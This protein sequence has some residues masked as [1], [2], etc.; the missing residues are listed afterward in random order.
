MGGSLGDCAIHRYM[1]PDFYTADTTTKMVEEY[2]ALTLQLHR[3]HQGSGKTFI[4]AN[5]E[6]DNALY[7]GSAYYIANADFTNSMRQRVPKHLRRQPQFFGLHRSDDPLD[8]S[9]IR[10]L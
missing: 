10:S 6:G 1:N 8:S 5:W 2:A 4:L 9:P 3:A 7:C